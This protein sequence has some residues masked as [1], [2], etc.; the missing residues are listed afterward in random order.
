MIID[1]LIFDRT[2][3]DV[4]RVKELT[5]RIM[6]NG[7][8]SLTPAE[9][10][11][12]LAGMKGAYNASD[13]NR[14][15]TAVAYIAARAIQL[16]SDLEDYREEREV[17]DD[18]MFALPYDPD[19]VDVDPKTDWSVS[20]IPTL[21]Q[22]KIYLANIENLRSLVTM[23]SGTPNTP[24]TLNGMTFVTANAMERIL[25]IVD[26]RL[27]E[28]ETEIKRLIDRVPPSYIFSGELLS[29]E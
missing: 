8:S 9:K 20:D 11:E 5:N 4:Q 1:E 15:G 17:S 27:T 23:P 25:W 12:Y 13:M 10:A 18:P 22:I 29:G 24:T 19:D 26:Q 28:I 6:R 16:P 14:V 21:A 2:T 7:L 3:E